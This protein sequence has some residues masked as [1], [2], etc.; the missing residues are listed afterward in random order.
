MSTDGFLYP[1]AELE[2]RGLMLRKGFPD[3][4]DVAAL[5]SFIAAARDGAPDLSAPIYSHETYDIVPD[6]R[7]MIGGSTC[8]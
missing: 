2:A 1:Y 4:Y 6:G 7:Q 5:Q 3:S 8:S